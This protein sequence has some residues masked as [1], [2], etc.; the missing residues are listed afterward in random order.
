MNTDSN[1]VTRLPDGSAFFTQDTPLPEDHWLFAVDFPAANR[2]ELLDR[3]N[4]GGVTDRD[5]AREKIK[6][7]VRWAY[8]ASSNNG[9]NL[10]I[11]PDSLVQNV[12]LALTGS[13]VS[14]D[15][16]DTYVEEP[17]LTDETDTSI[18]NSNIDYRNI[19]ELSRDGIIDV[20]TGFEF[21]SNDEGRVFVSVPEFV[22]GEPNTMVDLP[23]AKL[24]N[25][26]YNG[27]RNRIIFVSFNYDGTLTYTHADTTLN[28]EGM[29]VVINTGRGGLILIRED[30]QSK[31]TMVAFDTPFY[32]DTD[33]FIA[34][35]TTVP[36]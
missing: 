17:G 15:R 12:L 5:V 13:Q 21:K 31:A 29:T 28:R 10:D 20:R 30:G 7:A 2:S 26:P 11:D 27:K 8:R 23:L 32:I 36:L 19:A 4:L 35:Q 3:T 1:P 22:G 34:N 18:P 6:L 33:Q 9:K 14:P 25:D 24:I 16:P